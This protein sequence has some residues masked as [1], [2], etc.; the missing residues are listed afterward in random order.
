MLIVVQFIFVIFSSKS[1]IP[2]WGCKK[3]KKEASDMMMIIVFGIMMFF[4]LHKELLAAFHTFAKKYPFPNVFTK[5]NT[6][7]IGNYY[8]RWEN[9]IYFRPTEPRKSKNIVSH[10]SQQKLQLFFPKIAKKSSFVLAFRWF[11]FIFGQTFSH[12]ASKWSGVPRINR[13]KSL[14]MCKCLANGK[15]VCFC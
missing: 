13:D 3:I 14:N 2:L 1:F 5:I 7:T 15:V 12:N 11:L 8:S 9:G 6:I 10:D 4:I